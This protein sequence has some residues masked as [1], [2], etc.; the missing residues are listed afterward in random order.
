MIRVVHIAHCIFDD[1]HPDQNRLS[2]HPGRWVLNLAIAQNACNNMQTEIVVPVHHASCDHIGHIDGVRVHYLAVGSFS[3]A[4]ILNFCV[5]KRRVAAYVKTLNPDIVHAHGTES[6]HALAA[7][8]TRLPYVITAQGMLF[9]IM[10]ILNPPLLSI[11]RVLKHIERRA[12]L[13]ARQVIAKSDNVAQALAQ[14]FPH[15]QLHR[16]PNTFLPALLDIAGVH[17]PNTLVYVGTLNFRKGIHILADALEIASKSLTTIALNVVG[18]AGEH[19]SEYEKSNLEKIHGILGDRLKL[20]DRVPLK[21]VGHIVADSTALVA[22]SLDEMFGNQLIE[23]L[24]VGTHGIVTENTGLAE[25]AR[26]FGNATV[27][28]QQDPQALAGAIIQTLRRKD[29]PEREQARKRIVDYMGPET[30]AKAHY[31]LYQIILHEAH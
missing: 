25:N 26:R 31:D 18:N 13:N 17:S 21:D 28:P 10:P 24:L 7:Q 1:R 19:A 8:Q 29:F 4:L 14:S 27:I 15:L 23:A 3:R 16:I 5:V 20:H 11:Y 2:L 9:M 12:L 6:F 22:P 30:V